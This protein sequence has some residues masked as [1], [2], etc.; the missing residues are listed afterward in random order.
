MFLIILTTEIISP[1]AGTVPITGKLDLTIP[2]NGIGF[3]AVL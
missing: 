3:P 2:D 1:R